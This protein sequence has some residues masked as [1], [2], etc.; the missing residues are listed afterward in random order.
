MW[1]EYLNA[2]FGQEQTPGAF[3]RG[4]NVSES[5]EQ[6]H[7]SCQVNEYGTFPK[8]ACRVLA[9]VSIGRG[10][11]HELLTVS[12]ERRLIWNQPEN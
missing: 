8:K 9:E 6:D 2:H 5:L 4:P 1:T 12:G 11:A 3:S 10:A 7:I